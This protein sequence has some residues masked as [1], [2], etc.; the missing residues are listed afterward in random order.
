VRSRRPA[1][2]LSP[3]YDR[4]CT[5]DDGS[6][7]VLTT[8][9]KKPNG[10]LVCLPQDQDKSAKAE[11]TGKTRLL[12]SISDEHDR[13]AEE[14]TKSFDNFQ[15]AVAEDRGEQEPNED[16]GKKAKRLSD[17]ARTMRANL[18]DLR[19]ALADEHM[20]HR[21]KSIATF[22]GFD[23]S[24]KAFD[25]GEHLK[26]LRGEHDAY[27]AK[28][29]KSLDSFEEKCMKSVQDGDGSIDQPSDWIAGRTEAH[30]NP[31]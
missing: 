22:R 5:T 18:K 6:P 28:C 8:D 21:S 1:R 2:D 27:D 10:A 19:S 17:D 25:K 7:G 9:P 3:A 23:P 29:E 26:T 20:M 4:G 11:H 24:D 12:A 14:V 13:H 30:G 16:E 15:K 31:T